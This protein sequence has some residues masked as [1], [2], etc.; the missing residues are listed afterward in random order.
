MAHDANIGTDSMSADPARNEELVLVDGLGRAIGTATKERAHREGLLHEAF[1][2]VLCSRDAQGG[3]WKVLL[4]R[5]AEG[6]YHSAGLW[7]NSVCSHP[8]AGERLEDAVLRRTAEELGVSIPAATFV[9]SFIYRA[10]FENG[11]TEYEHD[12]VFVAELDSDR[13][14][15]IRPNPHEV[16]EIRWSNVDELA[17]ELA[18]RP[19][20]FTVWSPNA[21]SYAMKFVMGA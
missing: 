21:L 16:G 13:L 15:D 10:V 18:E 2:V 19:E 9:G 6:K 1:S 4:T 20:A 3:P 11:I 7:T 12:S 14:G 8:R 17:R 5:R